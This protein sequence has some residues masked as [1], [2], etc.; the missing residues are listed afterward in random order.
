MPAG[1][2]ILGFGVWLMDDGMPRW[3][4]V[5]V[6]AAAGACAG[7]ILAWAFDRIARV[8]Y[9]RF[10]LERKSTDVSAAK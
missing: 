6:G 3:M 8:L 7:L 5:L 9:R 2:G 10:L 1:V 4:I